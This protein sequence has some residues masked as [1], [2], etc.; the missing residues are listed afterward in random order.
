M[1]FFPKSHFKNVYAYIYIYTN[2]T[3]DVIRATDYI[4]KQTSHLYDF[5][6]GLYPF[7]ILQRT[8]NIYEARIC[9]ALL[10]KRK[11]FQS[12]LVPKTSLS[13]TVYCGA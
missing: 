2:S 12:N 1:P 5:T 10:F 6:S 13:L 7:C 9:M 3:L 4:L 11:Y 8:P